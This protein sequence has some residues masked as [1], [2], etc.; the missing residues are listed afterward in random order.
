MES[1]ILLIF[2]TLALALIVSELVG[3]KHIKKAKI[4]RCVIVVVS[5]LCFSYWFFEQ[6]S[7]TIKQ[8]SM[9]VQIMNKL[10]QPIDF[11]IL[12]IGHNDS[13]KTLNHLDIISPNNYRIEY[14][15]MAE[16]DEFWLV[17]YLGKKDIVYFTQYYVPNK[18]MDQIIEIN[19]YFNQN[20]KLSKSA[21][22]AIQNF[23]S[24]KMK[25]SVWVTLALLLLFL[26]IVKIFRKKKRKTIFG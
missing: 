24:N 23:R 17:G 25:N 21:N 13:S 9:V 18:D 6:S 3:A 8:N 15:D 10:P 14:L 1:F 26:N 12:K 4:F 22:E 19:N 20:Q 5:I 11:Y 16:S 7:S 2:F